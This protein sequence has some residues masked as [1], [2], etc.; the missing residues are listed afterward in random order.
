VRWINGARYLRCA[1]N[2]L[3]PTLS[4]S[5]ERERTELV[6]ALCVKLAGTF[7]TAIKRPAI[8]II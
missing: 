4:P 6:A 7:I 3:T 8:S 5:G 2:P 1:G